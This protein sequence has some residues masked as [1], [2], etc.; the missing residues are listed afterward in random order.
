MS[1]PLLVSTLRPDPD[2]CVDF[3]QEWASARNYLTGKPLYLIQGAVTEEYV[4]LPPSP[5]EPGGPYFKR[6]LKYNAHPPAAVLLGLPFA[7]LPYPDAVFAWNLV[8]LAA[9]AV[10]LELIRRQLRWTLSVWALGP[11]L[12]LTLLFHP[13]LRQLYQGQLNLILLLLLVGSWTGRRSAW[14]GAML[15]VAIAVKLFPAYLLLYFAF[16]R[17]W[18]AGVAAVVTV[19]LMNGLALAMFGWQDFHEYVTVIVPHVATSRSSWMN[20][21][22]PGLWTKLFD[23]FT[24]RERIDPLFRLP[25][26]AQALTLLSGLAVT[27]VVAWRLWRTPEPADRAD[28]GFGQ[29]LTGMVLLSPVAYDHY[30][31]LLIPALAIVWDRIPAASGPRIALL[32]VVVAFWIDPLAVYNKFI[33]GGFFD[34]HA[35]PGLTLTLLS[36]QLY[37]LLTL[38]VLACV[39]TRDTTPTPE[40]TKGR[41]TL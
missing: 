22:L 33:P 18:R 32:A 38:F 15:G 29:T 40:N 36:Y 20:M 37:A 28:P 30:V 2:N 10:A 14:G 7:P 24:E 12:T 23:P 31:L 11:F 16:R 5:T 6:L 9:F 19:L 26:L 27:A 3:F 25:I 8:S 4:G 17:C 34:G 41:A 21:S 1:G 13:L 35:G 39:L